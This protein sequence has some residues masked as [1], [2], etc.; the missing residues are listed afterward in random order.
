MT[1]IIPESE[2]IINPDG[3]VFHL[4]LKPEQISDK[5]VMMGD[6]ERVTIAASLFDS[7]EC[8][9]QNREFR[10]ITGKY[11]GTVTALSMASERTISTSYFGIGRFPIST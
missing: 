4:H 8:E 10:T 6:P 1:R 5:I 7:I 3:S 9:V 2:F 11:K